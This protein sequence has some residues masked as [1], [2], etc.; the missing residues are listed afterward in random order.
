MQFE[1]EVQVRYSQVQALAKRSVR[2]AQKT[3]AAV[4]PRELKCDMSDVK[5]ASV[6]ELGTVEIPVESII[7]TTVMNEKGVY[8]PD[9]MPI[10]SVG[11][12][13]A[14]QWCRL[15]M[16]YL[17]DEG[18]YAP[19][20]CIEFLGRFY[21]EDG[22]KRVSVL[23]AHGAYTTSAIVTRILPVK[24]EEK[25]IQN[26]YSFLQDYEKTGLY[27]TEFTMPDGFVKLQQALG[28][29]KDYVWNDRDR[30]HFLFNLIPVAF[31]M[32]STFGQR[33]VSAADALVMLL[34]NH[35]YQEIRKMQPWERSAALQNAWLKHSVAEYKDA[36]VDVVQK[37][38]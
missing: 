27:Q 28:H 26:Y 11:S 9:F 1:K 8:S 2:V 36:A 20:R 7:G 34:E 37:A 16:D 25:V 6:V 19:I 22:K 21:V 13:Y 31:A 33:N 15:Y 23:K 38:S 17:S 3:G 30:F 10:A 14:A 29:E 18:W 32:G 4:S 5:V 35:S 24:T 12:P